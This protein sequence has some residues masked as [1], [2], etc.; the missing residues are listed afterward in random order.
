MDTTVNITYTDSPLPYSIGKSR[1]R[2][3]VWVGGAVADVVEEVQY[4][5]ITSYAR[6]RTLYEKAR[7]KIPELAK[8][9]TV[10][11]QVTTFDLDS[12]F[13]VQRTGDVA[14]IIVQHLRGR[15]KFPEIRTVSSLIAVL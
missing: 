1:T 15:K 2:L 9:E 12:D 10:Y 8:A 14:K 4:D 11:L 13:A 6:F 7:E 3:S 5:D